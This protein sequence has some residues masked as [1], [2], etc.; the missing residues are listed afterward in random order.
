MGWRPPPGMQ[1]TT[2]KDGEVRIGETTGKGSGGPGKDGVTAELVSLHACG[3]GQAS[4]P[5][6][7]LLYFLSQW[8][9]TAFP[10]SFHLSF[11][12]SASASVRSFPS[13]RFSG[14]FHGFRFRLCLDS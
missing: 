8:A 12:A 1:V 4:F 9:R 11:L 10:L 2:G 13:F 6:R 3:S 7:E 14:L 5:I